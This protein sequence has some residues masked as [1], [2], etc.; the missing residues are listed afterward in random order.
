MDLAHVSTPM[1]ILPIL[2]ILCDYC[3]FNLW[4]QRYSDVYLAVD[5]M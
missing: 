1:Q 2:F 3:D 4:L 5:A